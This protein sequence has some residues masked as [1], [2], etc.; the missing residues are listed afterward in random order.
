MYKVECLQTR[1]GLDYVVRDH[2]GKII[3]KFEC[4]RFANAFKEYKEQNEI[5]GGRRRLS[6]SK[7]TRR[8]RGSRL[9][10]TDQDGTLSALKDTHRPQGQS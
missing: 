9:E 6:S 2:D 7:G 10:D 5:Q 8:R 3:G 1:D 4:E